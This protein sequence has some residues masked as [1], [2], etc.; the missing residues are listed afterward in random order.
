MEEEKQRLSEQT[1]NL[2]KEFDERKS[3][4]EISFKQSYSVMEAEYQK[5]LKEAQKNQQV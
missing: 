1:Q 4:Y 2:K 3:A 5:Q